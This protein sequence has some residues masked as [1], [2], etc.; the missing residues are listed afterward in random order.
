MRY[1]TYQP[2]RGWFSPSPPLGVGMSHIE[3]NDDRGEEVQTKSNLKR[4]FISHKN[5]YY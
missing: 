2:L 4:F 1:G 5:K 3:D